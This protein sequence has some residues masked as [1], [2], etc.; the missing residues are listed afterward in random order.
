MPSKDNA[1]NV[2]RERQANLQ[3]LKAK[4]ENLDK[5]VSWEKKSYVPE[6][7]RN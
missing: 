1:D 3:K 5:M 2:M 4:T 7:R 6:Y